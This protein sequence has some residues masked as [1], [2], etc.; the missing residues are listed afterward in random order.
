MKVAVEA[1]VTLLRRIG[2]LDGEGEALTVLGRHLAALPLPPATAKLLLW[3]VLMGCLDPLLTVACASA[4]RWGALQLLLP[5]RP[6]KDRP[7]QAGVIG[8]GLQM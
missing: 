4:F 5:R 2:A 1:A 6:S 7:R 3:G 8:Q